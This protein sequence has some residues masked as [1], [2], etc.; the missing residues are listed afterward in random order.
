MLRSLKAQRW[1]IE[2]HQETNHKYD[3]RPY[4]FHLK[5]VVEIAKDFLDRID[6]DDQDQVLAACWLHDTIEDCRVTYN[7][8]K[9]E[10]GIYTAD[11]VYALTNE[12]GKNRKERANDKYYEGI[13]STRNATFVKICDR[14]ANM[15]YSAHEGSSMF[16]KYVEEYPEFKARLLRD[17]YVPMFERMEYIIQRGTDGRKPIR[18][19]KFQVK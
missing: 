3:G 10:F 6:G 2:K 1:A 12:K 8:I 15:E 13:R 14:L 4:S 18:E 9:K 7:D 19:N 5:M 11:I 16:G 17:D